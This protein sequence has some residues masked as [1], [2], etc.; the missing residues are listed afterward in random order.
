M[1]PVEEWLT[2]VCFV[3]LDTV[4]FRTSQNAVQHAH[5][6]MLEKKVAHMLIVHPLC[7]P[8]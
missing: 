4:P 3:S 5:C 7:T 1:Q 8:L 2:L 6:S